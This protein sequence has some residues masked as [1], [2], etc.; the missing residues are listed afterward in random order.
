VPKPHA[1]F[2]IQPWFWPVLLAWLSLFGL[3]LIDNARGP[4]FPDILREFQLSDTAGSLFFLTAS[5]ASLVHNTL[6]F[7]FLSLTSP[8]RL[9]GIYTLI[10][11]AGA[12]LISYAT[13]YQWT[14]VACA[15]LG[16]GF[17]GLG[18]GQNAAVQ[19]AP[20]EHRQRAMGLLHTMYGLSSFSAPLFVSYLALHGWRF[21]LAILSLPSVFVGV[22]VVF[23]DRRKRKTEA[24]AIVK[25]RAHKM[26][27]AAEVEP[28]GFGSPSLK[29]ATWFAAS[30]I[31]LLVVGEISV[32]SRLA[33][34]ARREW[35]VGIESAGVWVAGYFAAMT[36]SRLLL[37]LF[38]FP[39]SARQLLYFSLALG[40]P[41]LL[42]GFM[43]LGFSTG[44]RLTFL[45]GFGFPIAMGYP[46]AMTRLAEIFGDQKQKVTSLCLITQSG[47]AM[48]MHFILGWGADT[49]GLLF[50]LGTVAIAALLGASASFWLLER[51][52]SRG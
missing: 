28:R 46:L 30:L 26:G 45:V 10:M 43:P 44:A 8:K 42:L 21:S 36:A 24:G 38:K 17:G 31:A 47:A 29:R 35:G 20:P 39:F 33:L 32:S 9:V 19:E 22:F 6:F 7:R 34:L 37:G 52:V 12:L 49:S 27:R 1:R 25:A 23:E 40:F 13:S 41:F 15:V 48:F 5:V 3:G 14:L 51:A 18:V 50:V 16:V 2:A 4:V 11:A